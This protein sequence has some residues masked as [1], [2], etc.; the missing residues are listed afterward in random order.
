MPANNEVKDKEHGA[1]E[2]LSFFYLFVRNETEQM[3][4]DT[5]VHRH[6]AAF[7]FGFRIIV[8]NLKMSH[9]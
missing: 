3:Y 5:P 2:H 7:M 6:I 9:R 8:T 4:S 1:T